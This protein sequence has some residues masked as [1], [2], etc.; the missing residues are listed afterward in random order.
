M[1]R[2][3]GAPGSR[4]VEAFVLDRSDNGLQLR[5]PTPFPC[6]TLVKIDGENELIL[7]KVC[8]CEPEKG[9]Y[10]LGIQLSAPL[11]SLIELELLNRAPVGRGPAGNAES[12]PGLG[13][14]MS[15]GPPSNKM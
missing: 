6:D 4:P 8:H 2:V 13:E 1:L 12:H 11:A 10:R 15:L 9:A 3:L 7:G 14:K 5:V